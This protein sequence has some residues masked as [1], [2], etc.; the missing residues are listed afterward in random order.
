MATGEGRTGL[1]AAART[2]QVRFAAAIRSG[3]S[4]VAAAAYADHARLLAP[5]ADPIIGR[6]GIASFWRAGLSAGIRAVRRTPSLIE[7]HG[8]VGLEIGHY[9]IRLRPNGGPLVVD[10]GAYLLLH[11]RDAGGDWRWALEM[12]TPDGTPR[13]A[14]AAPAWQ[15]PEVGDRS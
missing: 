1:E 5:A 15:G 7:R 14:P 12:F 9:A 3:D 10:R 13:I 4:T 8:D 11:E 2:A 6:D